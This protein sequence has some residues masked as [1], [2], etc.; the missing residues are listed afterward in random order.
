[1]TLN[2]DARQTAMLQEM[3][4]RV[5]APP[6]PAKPVAAP[7][8]V[9]VP[10]PPVAVPVVARAPAGPPALERLDWEALQAAVAQQ[11]PAGRKP[12]FGAGDRAADW[13]VVGDLPS[14]D[15]EVQ[16]LPFAGDAGRLL[17]NMLAAVGASR[18]RGAYLTHLLKWRPPGNRN[19]EPGEM[20]GCEPFLRQQLE[21]V[22]PR[23]IL[24]MGRFAVQALLQSGEPIGKLRGRVHQWHQVP[25]V[26]TY[27]P[28]YLLRN[29]ADKARAWADLCMARALL[30]APA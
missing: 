25:V 13:M 1:V 21:L 26:V 12:I 3:G 11:V 15:D 17:D 29:P 30:G 19:P 16:G 5:F 7:R 20:A 18:K 22:Q 10:A 2:L 23:V 28:A 14:E 6:P 24:A 8:P 27:H 4:V 9:A